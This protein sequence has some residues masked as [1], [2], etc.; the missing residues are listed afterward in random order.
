MSN[1]NPQRMKN[2][3]SVRSTAQCH[4][5]PSESY[6]VSALG[7]H[8]L[9][10][11]HQLLPLPRILRHSQTRRSPLRRK[12]AIAQSPGKALRHALRFLLEPPQFDGGGLGQHVDHD[13]VDSV[14]GGQ[15]VFDS[16]DA[17]AAHH[18]GDVEQDRRVFALC[19]ALKKS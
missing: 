15:D 11:L 1:V 14:I 19:L 7:D 4:Q 2:M 9:L 17:R 18:A 10:L 3:R 5:S 6:A 12:T 8:F 13:R 16:G